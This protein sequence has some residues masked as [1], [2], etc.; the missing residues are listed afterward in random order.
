MKR[1]II[2]FFVLALI[3]GCPNP[4]AKT[5]LYGY[6]ETSNVVGADRHFL[7]IERDGS[8]RR[9]NYKEGEL[10]TDSLEEGTWKFQKN[11][12]KEP[13]KG[14]QTSIKFVP[15]DGSIEYSYQFYYDSVM[16]LF[17]ESDGI[18]SSKINYYKM[19]KGYKF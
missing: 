3:L 9:I 11:K 1:N 10:V 5:N 18:T 6:W 19:P 2:V 15:N 13:K 16:L 7:D 17:I 12:V 14:I 8:Y 4:G